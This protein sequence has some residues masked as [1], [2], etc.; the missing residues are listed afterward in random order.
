MNQRSSAVPAEG[1]SRQL[2]LGPSS[3][4]WVTAVG[5][6]NLTDLKSN[7]PVEL[8]A[9]LKQRDYPASLNLVYAI[10]AAIMGI[11]WTALPAGIEGELKVSVRLRN[12]EL[13]HA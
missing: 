12:R 4:G 10:R 11:H 2:N 6:S 8:Y 1:L 3:A 13:D 7:D 9:T 5:S